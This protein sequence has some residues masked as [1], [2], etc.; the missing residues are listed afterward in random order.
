MDTPGRAQRTQVSRRQFVVGTGMVAVAGFPAIVR[1]QP[2]PVKIGIMHP[3]TGFL[4]YSGNQ[5]RAGAVMAV[6]EINAGGGIKA[7]GGARI[8]P[9]L[10]DNQSKVDVGASEFEKLNEAGIAAFVGPY[11]S[12][13]GI[14][15]SQAATR[16]GL[17]HVCDVTVSDR[18]VSKDKPTTFRFS[19]GYTSIAETAISRLDEINKSAGGIAKTVMMV[20]EE[21]ESGAG[22]QKMLAKELPKY[23]FDIVETVLHP[24]PTRDFSNIV[25]RIRARNPDILIIGNYYDEYVLLVRTL[26]QQRVRLK[27]VYSVLGGGASSF[28]FV[29]ESA[30]AAQHIMDTNHWYNPLNPKALDLR[31]RVEAKGL[32]FSYEVYL[33][34]NAVMWLADSIERARS[35]KREAIVEALATSTWS[36][37]VLPYGP[38]KI[39]EGQNTGALAATLQV[40][41]P[42]IQVI[43]PK[44]FASAKLV[45]PAPA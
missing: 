38:T 43:L 34:Y 20:H 30:D 13:I 15:T 11:A 44:Q 4:A 31:K 2:A 1:A 12:A 28:R 23:G 14:A 45:F 40:Q 6:E 16:Y 22:T 19:P 7:L 37:H 39:V 8:E 18:V 29:R 17:P 3:I 26:H 35:A 25:L 36:G 21:S 24:N 5:C 10:A 33:N 9:V 41:G 32:D 42:D 27:G